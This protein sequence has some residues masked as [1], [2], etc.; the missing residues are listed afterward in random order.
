MLSLRPL[1]TI[2]VCAILASGCLEAVPSTPA[3]VTAVGDDSAVDLSWL[4]VTTDSLKLYNVYMGTDA[5][6]LQQAMTVTVPA[7]RVTIPNLINGTNY[8]FAVD[9]ENFLGQRSPKSSIVSATPNPPATNIN[10]SI[11]GTVPQDSMSGVS[12]TSEIRIEFNEPMNIA[13][14]QVTVEPSLALGG[15]QWLSNNRVLKFPLAPSFQASTLYRFTVEGQDME[16]HDLSFPKTFA[17]TTQDVDTTPPTII[18]TS[19]ANGQT[20]FPCNAAVQIQ[21]SE[22]MDPGRNNSFPISFSPDFPWYEQWSPDH[23]ILAILP[24]YAFPFSTPYSFTISTGARDV[25]GNALVVPYTST[26][27]TVAAPDTT[28]PYVIAV[29]PGPGQTAAS[30][31]PAIQITFSEP[32]DTQTTGNNINVTSY[33]GTVVGTRSWNLDNT[34]FTFQPTS[35]FI[36]G[37]YVTVLLTDYRDVAGNSSYN[38]QTGFYVP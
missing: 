31:P 15:A 4:P 17:F 3:N 18:A 7:T 24:V 22:P 6:G 9:A 14:V 38:F 29:S 33:V 1:A 13:T 35:P 8:Y 21:F 5:T 12:I 34:V 36:S 37:E 25:A 2:S 16:G 20:N 26:F 32:M 30:N 11:I 23:T 19:P 10:P 28:P 27:V